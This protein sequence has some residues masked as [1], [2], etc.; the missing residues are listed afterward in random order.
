MVPHLAAIFLYPVK[1]LDPIAVPSA[2]L[3]KCGGLDGDRFFALFDAAGKYVNGKRHPRVQ[4]LRSH[5]DAMTRTLRLRVQDDPHE[6]SWHVDRQRRQLEEWLGEYFGFPVTFKENPEAGFPD[7]TDAPGPTVIST[8][9]Y[10]EIASWFPGLTLEQMR[11]RFRA[12]LEI[13]GVPPFWEDRLYAEKPNRIRFQI[14]DVEFDGNNPCRR[15]AVPPR[16]PFTAESSPADFKTTFLRRREETLPPWAERSRFDHFYRLS[17][18]TLVPP[19]EAGKTLRIG[20]EIRVIGP[21]PQ[22]AP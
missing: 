8:A 9:T 6:R 14:G 5:Y 17:V 12:N 7:D 15:C 13:G 16:D 10:L 19:A 4:R 22:S 20:D 2:R 21:S 18:N 3:L 1:S 11:I